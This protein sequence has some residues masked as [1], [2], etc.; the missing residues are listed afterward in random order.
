V[1]K[2]PYTQLA[3]AQAACAK[4]PKCRGITLT[5]DEY[6]L[7]TVDY[8]DYSGSG[9]V[10]LRGGPVA[11]EVTY[12]VSYK[13]HVWTVQSPVQIEGSLADGR[14]F[15]K[16]TVALRVR[17]LLCKYIVAQRSFFLFFWSFVSYINFYSRRPCKK[18]KL[19]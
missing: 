6:R 8:V 1:N 16:Y 2:T 14:R 4:N 17:F 5:G 19:K 15:R 11:D 9:T 3:A 10:Y 13:D 18:F 7:N 12:E